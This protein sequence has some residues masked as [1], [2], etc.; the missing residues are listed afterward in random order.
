MQLQ[1]RH[2]DAL[3]LAEKLM[4]HSDFCPYLELKELFTDATPHARSQFRYLFTDYYGLNAGGLTDAFRDRFF[5]ILFG[6]N[7]IVN[8][9]PDFA[10]ILNELS[11]FTRKKGDFAMQFS[12]VSK[13]V[14]MHRESRPLYDSHVQDFFGEYAPS[15]HTNHLRQE[16]SQSKQDRI[17]WFIGFLDRIA[18]DYA[19]WAQDVRIVPIINRLKAR[20]GRLALCDVI[21]LVD[22]LVYKV[23]NQ[24]LL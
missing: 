16:T 3:D 15:R 17:T 20:D 21:R 6:G 24:R 2:I 1:K 12:F 9:Q 7:V 8:G 23:G 14:G 22:F 11:G 13:L 18:K 10:A 5:E 4:F 19:A